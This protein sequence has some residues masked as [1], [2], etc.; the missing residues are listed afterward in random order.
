MRKSVKDHDYYKNNFILKAT[1]KHG[2]KYDYSEV[3]YINSIE[4]VKIICPEHGFFYVRPDAHVRKVG[5][6]ECNGGV[7]YTTDSFIEKS[8]KLHGESYVYSG[9]EY[10]NS[11][12]KVKIICNK[13]GEFLIRPVNHLQGQGCPSCS[14]VKQHDTKSFIINSMKV[15]SDRY[16]YTRVFYKN[17]HT[18]VEIICKNHGIFFQTPKDHMNGSGCR[19][20]NLS[21]GEVMLEN[22]L[23]ILGI[24]YIR[25]K[26]FQDCIGVGG[27]KLP[28]DFYLPKYNILIEYDGRQHFEPVDK[29]GGEKTFDIL[30]KN[31]SLRERWCI[32][33]KIKLIRIKYVS[34][35]NDLDYLYQ[36]ILSHDRIKNIR[37]IDIYIKRREDFLNF[38]RNI[39]EQII[40]DF[41][42]GDY[43]CDVF[44]PEKK[45]GF[46]FLGLF[47]DSELNSD[48]NQQ[49]NL[50]KEFEKKSCKV[51][52]IYEDQWDL[53]R[54]IIKS[55][56]MTMLLKSNKI[57]ARK[58]EIK[59][60]IDNK[61]VRNFLENNH[62][63]G[64]IGSRIKIGLFYN[65]E[66]VSLMTFGNLRR[67]LGSKSQFG[68]YEML[69]FCNKLYTNVIGGASRLF[70]Y[71]MKKYNPINVVSYADKL[72]SN[73]DNMYEKIG[74]VYSG[75]SKPS[76]YYIVDNIR[77]NRFVY[78]K[79]ILV[80][81]GF[82]SELSERE[83]CSS[84]GLFRI[85]DC[86]T[87]VYEIRN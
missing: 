58:C 24:D 50:K 38:F 30:K 9:V 15:H 71:F 75:S 53:K 7:K 18:K 3:E 48:K 36:T 23:K 34:V 86:G 6:P 8:K 41:K 16:D 82:N 52:Q 76:Y 64:F 42:L 14:G 31:D 57:Y 55:R 13:H 12:K 77:K 25:E 68:S 54:D 21:K 37:C 22:R 1:K 44:L 85:Y 73:R 33:K 59:E 70:N 74:M 43:T 79:D 81:Q 72:W 19:Y 61:L 83:I 62:I 60:I 28:F 67:S 49:L 45:L 69:R 4:K 63:Q 2:K 39:N 29:F 47:K 5:C 17:N 80:K 11:T 35:E 26:K 87:F 10:V 66:L 32:E 27:Y 46:K 20:C 78:R 65:G 84:L 40:F 56:I 51:V